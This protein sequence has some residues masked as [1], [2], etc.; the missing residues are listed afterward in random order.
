MASGSFG[1]LS[2]GKVAQAG[3]QGGYGLLLVIDHGNGLS[4]YYGHLS[5]VLVRVGQFVEQGQVVAR[6]G[7]TGLSTG[8][9]LH[10][11]IR[12]FGEPVDP[13]PWLP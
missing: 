12:R 11:E 13:L 10:F 5:E 3:W 4:T 1:S 7:N 9:H 2:F 8:P 6:S